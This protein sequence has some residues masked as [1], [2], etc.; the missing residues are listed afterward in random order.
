MSVMTI[1]L[2]ILVYGCYFKTIAL[3]W[4]ILNT[5]ILIYCDF[6]LNLKI[7]WLNCLIIINVCVHNR[8]KIH[9]TTNVLHKNSC[10]YFAYFHLSPIVV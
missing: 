4:S 9:N 8:S 10:T 6:Y 5:Y 7:D 1:L 3:E 2:I